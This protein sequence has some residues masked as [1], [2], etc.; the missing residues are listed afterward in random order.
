[1]QVFVNFIMDGL[2]LGSVYAL[3][4][5]GYT[6]VYGIAKMLNFAHGDVIMVGGYTIYI[7]FLQKDM[8]IAA[9]VIA[10]VL[11]CSVLGFVIEKLAYRPL[12]NATP[13]SVLIT[14]IGVSYLLQNIALLTFT[15]ELKLISSFIKLPTFNVGPVRIEGISVLIWITTLVIMVSLNNFIQ[16]TKTGKA[17]LAVSED[18]GAAQLM[19]IDVNKTISITFLIGSALAGLAS[20][21][22]IA[23]YQK[24]EPYTGSVFGI[25][26]FAAAVFGGI[27]S[28]P[29]AALGGILIGL[30]EALA[31]GYLPDS[32][33]PASD[34]VAFAILIIMLV[35]K[36]S[37]MLGKTKIEKV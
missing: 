31:I 19:G 23:K 27:G 3:V 26:A 17:M 13:L 28:I 14:A 10:S 32:I 20:A 16:K 25:K 21:L 22:Y 12:R 35:L 6:M 18:R 7:V 29:G 5:L 15:S 9:A 33:R 34:G 37:G 24:I 8:G 4:A 2:N 11:I 36:P 30:I 1:M